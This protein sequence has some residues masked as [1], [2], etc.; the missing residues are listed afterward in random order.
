VIDFND[1]TIRNEINRLADDKQLKKVKEM[2][3]WWTTCQIHDEVQ[4][5]IE[6]LADQNGAM[7]MTWNLVNRGSVSFTF[8]FMGPPW[9]ILSKLQAVKPRAKG[10]T[11]PK[12]LVKMIFSR[13]VK[14]EEGFQQRREHIARYP[15]SMPKDYTVPTLTRQNLCEK[16]DT[17]KHAYMTWN[18]DKLG[19]ELRKVT[20]RDDVTEE[21]IDQAW[22]L[23]ETYRIMAE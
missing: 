2:A 22:S 16:E 11:A 1:E 17:S 13:I 6:K 18:T 23:F 8:V 3:Y 5:F 19:E 15:D 14:L 12:V 10:K 21:L 7:N 20:D 4:G 9:L